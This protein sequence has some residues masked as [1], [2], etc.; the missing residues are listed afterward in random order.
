MLRPNGVLFSG[1]T[2]RKGVE[3]CEF[4]YKKGNNFLQRYMKGVPFQAK[5]Y[6]KGYTFLLKFGIEKGKGSR[7]RAEHLPNRFPIVHL[8]IYIFIIFFLLLFVL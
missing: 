4:L 2:Y 1:W 6:K 5:R 7:V 3:I 8:S